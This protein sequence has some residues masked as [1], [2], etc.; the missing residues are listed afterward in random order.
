MS[1]TVASSNLLDDT[2]RTLKANGKSALMPFITLGDPTCEITLELLL[3]MEQAG[4]DIIELGIP[5]SDP[6][7][8]GPVIERASA[9]ALR[10]QVSIADALRVAAQAR[11]R[12][13]GIPYVLFTYYNPILQFGLDS[14]VQ[15]ASKAGISGIII[16]D[17]PYEESHEVR[18][19]ADREGIHL[20]PLVAPTSEARVGAI[21][22][23]GRGFIYCVSSLGVTGVRDSFDTQVD[24]FI[25]LVRRSTELPIAIGF[26]ISTAA[27][28]RHFAKR[29]DGV[30]VGSAIVR[31]IEEALPVLEDSNSAAE[32]I[33]QICDF[34]RQLK[35]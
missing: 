23:E 26:G 11:K 17:L 25:D 33:L 14:F 22:A 20:I 7:A 2:F 16:P 21:V 13:A 10:N 18:E 4:A 3:Q 29:C 12:G 28:V 6:L 27:H 1:Q 24:G 31:R 35:H 34:V 30:I 5:Y 32:G 9:R 8:D 19:A 15:E